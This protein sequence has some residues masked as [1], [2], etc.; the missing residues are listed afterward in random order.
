MSIR[1]SDPYVLPSL[2]SDSPPPITAVPMC[3]PH[4]PQ[5]HHPITVV[6]MCDPHYPQIHPDHSGP[7]V[8]SLLS[9][10]L[11]ITIFRSTTHHSAFYISFSLSSG[12]PPIT[13]VPICH[14]HYPQVHRRSQR[15]LRVILSF[16]TCGEMKPNLSD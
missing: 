2:S 13:A 4:Y 7:D 16:T 8:S 14:R 1:H 9:L 15:S 12:L 6:P 10:R 11:T 5:V 3:R